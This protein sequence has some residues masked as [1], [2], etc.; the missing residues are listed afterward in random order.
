MVY[1]LHGAPTIA[2]ALTS[3]MVVQPESS[4]TVKNEVRNSKCSWKDY[5]RKLDTRMPGP[6]TNLDEID[7]APSGT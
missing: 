5:D 7:L 2:L 1:R 3:A 4:N 6:L